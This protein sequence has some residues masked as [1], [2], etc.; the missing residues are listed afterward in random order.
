[1]TIKSV[2]KK[3]EENSI[4]LTG[5]DG[6]AD[7]LLALTRRLAKQLE[8]DANEIMTRMTSGDYEN[9]V[10]VFEEEFGEYITIY[11]QK[12]SRNPPCNWGSAQNGYLRTDEVNQ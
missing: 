3:L 6:N 10:A 7:Q 12:N 8:L 9:L 5:P 4:D 1:M 2:K 11:R